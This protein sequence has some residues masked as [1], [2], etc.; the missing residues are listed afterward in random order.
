MKTTRNLLATA[1]VLA[2]L[3]C[4]TVLFALER[5]EAGVM[6]LTVAGG[7]HLTKDKPR[8]PKAGSSGSKPAMAGGV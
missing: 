8:P 6:V 1:V 4:A 3:I 7:A 5:W 2:S